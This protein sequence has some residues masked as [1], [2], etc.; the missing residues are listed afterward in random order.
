ME[1]RKTGLDEQGAYAGAWIE[2]SADEISRTTP[3]RRI[4]THEQ[5]L[6]AHLAAL[7]PPASSLP[8]PPVTYCL[9][10]RFRQGVN[11]HVPRSDGLR[12]A[13]R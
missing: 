9:E 13:L 4:T 10:G 5:D 3:Q 6:K 7:K 11:L 12:G 1:V 2:H 8:V